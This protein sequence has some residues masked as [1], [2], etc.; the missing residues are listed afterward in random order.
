MWLGFMQGSSPDGWLVLVRCSDLSTFCPP[1][2]PARK[3]GPAHCLSACSKNCSDSPLA[4]CARHFSRDCTDADEQTDK[5]CVFMELTFLGISLQAAIVLDYSHAFVQNGVF[6]DLTLKYALGYSTATESLSP[7]FFF[8]FFS[9]SF[10]SFSFPIRSWGVP[11]IIATAVTSLT[12][13]PS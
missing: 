8:L 2:S 7:F 10:S 9:C 3:A 6:A 11:K 1:S 5:F 12:F 4:P 13:F